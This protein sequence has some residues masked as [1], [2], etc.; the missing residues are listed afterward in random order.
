MSTPK[1]LTSRTKARGNTPGHCF[2]GGG[3]SRRSPSVSSSRF[4]TTTPQTKTKARGNNPGHCFCGGGGSRRSPSVSSSRFP[5]TTPQTKTKARGNNP[6]H[7]F[8]GGG[9]NRTRV[10]RRL[11]GT[12]P[13]AVCFRFS[14]P[15]HSH[16]Q[17]ADGDSHCSLSRKPPRP[18]LLVSSLATPGQGRER[19]PWL[20]DIEA[21]L[22]RRGRRQIDCSWQSYFCR[23]V[24][25]MTCILCPL[26]PSQ[27]TK[28][29]PFTPILNYVTSVTPEIGTFIPLISRRKFGARLG[30]PGPCQRAGRSRSR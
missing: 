11:S 25:E 22:M 3:G 10:L 15:R 2:C 28:S 12:S 18:G 8:C 13:G 29:R 30:L 24:Q 14:L 16:R 6:G 26:L 9:G 23:I 7:C 17:D 20:T 1:Y 19:A 21:R 27:R 4:P 5:T